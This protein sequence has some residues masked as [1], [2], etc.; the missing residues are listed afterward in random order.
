MRPT[1]RSAIAMDRRK[2]FDGV[3]RCGSLQN[4]NRTTR[5][6]PIVKRIMRIMPKATET[7]SIVFHESDIVDIQSISIQS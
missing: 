4:A 2:L 1:S 7:D 5:L 3:R 6:P